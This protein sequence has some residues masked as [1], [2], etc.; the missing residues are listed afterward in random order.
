MTHEEM[1]NF[2]Y[3]ELSNFTY[4]KL[5]L[6]KSELLQT[7]LNGC[8]D[9]IPNATL[10]KLQELCKGFIQ[11]CDKYN[12][13]IPKEIQPIKNKKSL[14]AMDII[15]VIDVIV[16]ILSLIYNKYSTFNTQPIDDIYK[17]QTINYIVNENY[18]NDVDIIIN[19]LT[20]E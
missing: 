4:L 20:I 13:D 3:E 14:S 12:I 17:N 6:E 8:R 9:N 2:T 16:K 11:S 7:I 19:E 18:I 10:S 5:S 15:R 1:S